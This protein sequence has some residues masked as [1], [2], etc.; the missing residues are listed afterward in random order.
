MKAVTAFWRDVWW[1]LRHPAAPADASPYQLE[2]RVVTAD[3]AAGLGLT[4]DVAPPH[5]PEGGEPYRK[6][7]GGHSCTHKSDCV[8]V[9]QGR[10]PCRYCDNAL[11]P[12]DCP[13]CGTPIHDLD[14]VPPGA[15]VPVPRDALWDLVEVAKWVAAERWSYVKQAPYV[16]STAR[17][18][19]AALDDAGLLDQIG[20]G[21]Q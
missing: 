16:A 1:C 4:R 21:D 14:A 17:V 10:R 7:P 20:E 9:H 11:C 8:Y 3:E 19:L 12:E 15:T 18:A 6:V 13:E 5:C 2:R